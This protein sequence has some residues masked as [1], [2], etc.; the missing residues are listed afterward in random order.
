M[1]FA[2]LHFLMFAQMGL[3]LGAR[4]ISNKQRQFS[5]LSFPSFLWCQMAEMF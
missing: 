4:F 5:S 3:A 2:A 1:S